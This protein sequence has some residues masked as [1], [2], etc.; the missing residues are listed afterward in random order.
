[1]EGYHAFVGTRKDRF[2]EEA[3]SSLREEKAA[4]RRNRSCDD[5]LYVL[6]HITEQCKD[7]QNSLIL[8]FFDFKKAFDCVPR[9]SMWN[10]LELRGISVEIV[11]IMRNRYY[12]CEC[13]VRVGQ[14]QN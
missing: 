11:N 13:C 9:G 3:Q 1:M 2:V 7:L 4:F 5:Q 10:I 12:A 6:R 14:G 8:N